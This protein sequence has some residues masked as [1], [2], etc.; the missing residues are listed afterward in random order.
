MTYLLSCSNTLEKNKKYK[1]E[2][3]MWSLFV[4]Y[5]FLIIYKESP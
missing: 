3:I 4:H 2:A 1:L 5:L